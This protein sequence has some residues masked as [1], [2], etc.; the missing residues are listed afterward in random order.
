MKSPKSLA[1][2]AVILLAFASCSPAPDADNPRKLEPE[3][4]F[5]EETFR[6][7]D[8]EV[9]VRIISSSELEIQTDDSNL[10]FQYTEKDGQI[11]AVAS[12][13]GTQQALYFARSS[14][15]LKGP[16]GDDLLDENNFA[17]RT[18]KRKTTIRLLNNAR[19]LQLVMLTCALDNLTIGKSKTWPSEIADDLEG[20]RAQLVEDNYLTESDWQVLH[21][22]F[23][24]GRVSD[25]DPSNTILVI[26]DNFPGSPVP[27]ADQLKS[28]DV[29]VFTKGGDGW[30][31][32]PVAYESKTSDLIMPQLLK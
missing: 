14:V 23:L 7:E 26:S 28:K 32:D 20:V 10:I 27:K 1:V 2:P 22:H 18:E 8:G 29:I 15:G 16:Q 19:Q 25:S 13:N 3:S 5:A 17:Q 9:A 12:I 4:A 6:S 24:I 11:R 30:I 21:R 31:L